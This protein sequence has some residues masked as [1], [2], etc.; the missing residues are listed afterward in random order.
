MAQTGKVNPNVKMMFQIEILEALNAPEERR[1]DR[2]I[3][4][5][6]RLNGEIK[7]I[8]NPTGYAYLGQVF[9]TQ[10]FKRVAGKNGWPQLDISL[11]DRAHAVLEDQK[12]VMG[13]LAAVRQYIALVLTIDMTGEDRRNLIPDYIASLANITKNIP[14]TEDIEAVLLRFPKIEKHYKLVEQTM[15]V[16]AAG[17]LIY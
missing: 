5:I 8:L 16:L 9:T 3:S 11:W 6:N 2:E 10:E 7:K 12:A 4:E 13:R 1:I 17:Q 14:R 15:A